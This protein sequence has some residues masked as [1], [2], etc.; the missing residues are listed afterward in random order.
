MIS[1]AKWQ[2]SSVSASATSGLGLRDFGFARRVALC[3]EIRSTR[4]SH[5]H[6]MHC[7]HCVHCQLHTTNSIPQTL[8]HTLH[9]TL[10]KTTYH[11]TDP[12]PPV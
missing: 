3:K 4:T 8:H 5:I 6:T 1:G 2:P 10:Y 11:T 7:I 12:S 9:H